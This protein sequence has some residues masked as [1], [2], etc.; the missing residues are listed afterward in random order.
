MP[1]KISNKIQSDFIREI[2]NDDISSG[3]HAT[4]I[5]RFPPE[6]NGYLHLGHA[7]SIC[8]NFG[9]A[10]ENKVSGGRCHLRFDDTNPTKEETEYVESIKKD[11][12]W[13]GFDWGEH[14]YFASDNF[15]K[16]Y[17]WAVYLISN[18][19]AYVDDLNADEIREYRGSLTEPGKDSPHR[20]RSVDDN[21]KLFSKMREGA[22]DEGDKV[23]RAKIDM[24]HPNINMRD[25]VIYRIIKTTHHRTGDK[26][27]IYPSYDFAHGQCD[28]LE[29]ITHSLCT[30]EFEQHRP[31]YEWFIDKLPVQSKPRQIEFSKLQPTF[32]LLSKRKLIEM[33][34]DQYVDGWDDPRMSTLSGLRRRGF[35]PQS[36][37][38]FCQSIGITKFTGVTDIALLE[39]SVR[40]LLNKKAKR[41]MVVLDPIRINI[42]NWPNKDHI[43][44]MN[45]IN[46]PED[47]ES[48]KRQI[49]LDGEVY[50]ERDDFMENPPK[51]YHRLSPG[52]EVR[53]RYSYCIRC[54]E[55]IR[56][57]AG[58]VIELLCSYD[59]ETLGKN[60][61]GRKVRAAIH[62]VPVNDSIDAEIRLYDRTFTVEDPSAVN[63]WRECFNHKALNVLKDCKLESSL[64]DALIDQ[65]FQF[66][67]KGYF[68]V[69]SKDSTKEKL[70]FNRTIA[71]RDTWAKI[72]KS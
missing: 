35:P 70:V 45:A 15:E 22:F 50:I 71:L 65:S 51:K 64:R 31:L 36:L 23:L 60:P 48:G 9:V 12:K 34:N 52:T 26:W 40:E 30:L 18:N 5:T 38:S 62:W 24:S 8:L 47:D 16:L 14:I 53:L 67:R 44:F 11:I 19:I 58:N 37:I 43:E 56:D 27:C 20:N 69:D 6:P 59:P 55:V 2:I 3:K 49:P 33:V 41:K 10:N 46:N 28:S 21:L 72:N 7:K 17:E 1:E 61:E 4:S 25:P 54:D 32:T 29:A 66:E 68:C 13:L 39:H 42:T 63:D 57:D